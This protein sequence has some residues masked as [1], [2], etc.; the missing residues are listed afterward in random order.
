MKVMLPDLGS[1]HSDLQRGS[2]NTLT[3]LPPPLA[4][5][6]VGLP[7]GREDMGAC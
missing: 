4:N 1:W 7:I 6:L 5:L 3:S 2:M